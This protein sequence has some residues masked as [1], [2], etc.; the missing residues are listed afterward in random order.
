VEILVFLDAW[1]EAGNQA[2]PKTAGRIWDTMADNA[3]TP[4]D[5]SHGFEPHHD[6][7]M[8]FRTMASQKNQLAPFTPRVT[9]K[10]DN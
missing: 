7:H 8:Y 4:Q 2:P 5:E 1:H 6:Q 10:Y 9:C 3:S